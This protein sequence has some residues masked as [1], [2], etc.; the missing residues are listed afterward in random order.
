MNP[1][2][3]KNEH[4]EK[5]I[6]KKKQEKIKRE[7]ARKKQQQLKAQRLM[8]IPLIKTFVLWIA[9]LGVVHLFVEFFAPLLIKFTAYSVLLIGKITFIPVDFRPVKFIDVFGYPMQIVV[10]CTA[11][12]Y[13]LFSIA[14]AVFAKWTIKDKIKNGLLF[15]GVVFLMNNFRFLLLGFIGQYYPEIFDTLHDYFWNI[16][17]ALITLGLWL[18]VNEKSQNRYIEQLPESKRK[19][20]QINE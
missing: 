18:I 10:E 20:Y 16:I 9:L 12:N 5:H 8:L 15:I 17:F 2:K 13:Y 7:E 14:L 1:R 11:Y 19:Y 6:S 4:K 3:K